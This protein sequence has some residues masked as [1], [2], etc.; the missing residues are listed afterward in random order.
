VE[1]LYGK[2]VAGGHIIGTATKLSDGSGLL[3]LHPER[4]KAAAHRAGLDDEEYLED[5]HVII[6]ARRYPEVLLKEIIPGL[7]IVGVALAESYSE[8]ASSKIPIVSGLGEELMHSVSEDELLILDASGGKLIV[9]PDAV[10]IAAYQESERSKRQVDIGSYESAALTTDDGR[11]ISLSARV[12]NYLDIYTALESGV[13]GLFVTTGNELLPSGPKGAS[14]DD[15]VKALANLIATIGRVP[16]FLQIPLEQ[17][18]F[19]ALA[20]AACKCSLHVV[21]DQVEIV[22][23]LITQLKFVQ[24]GLAANHIKHGPVQFDA[25]LSTSET[26]GIM[27]GSLTG[28]SGVVVSDDLI[29]G[30]TEN[31]VMIGAMAQHANKPVV[32]SLPR[33]HWHAP[34][35]QALMLGFTGF[36]AFPDTLADVKQAIRVS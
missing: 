6:V 2:C 13:D 34:L 16:L 1:I 5:T 19:A 31:L 30:T 15:Q 32:L 21:I 9:D 8:V 11:L 22:D 4:L 27:I 33:D 36:V 29:S 18:A 17:I 25:L 35:E 23:N 12:N 14:V 7:V 20:Q 3:S 26:G 28:F 10:T 24:A